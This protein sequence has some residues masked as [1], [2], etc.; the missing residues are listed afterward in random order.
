[1]STNQQ[2]LCLVVKGNEGYSKNYMKVNKINL[3]W[4]ASIVWLLAGFNVLKIGVETYREY[5]T[6]LNVF[7]SLIIFIIF[8]V[9]VFKKLVIKHTKR[10]LAFTE[11]QYFWNFFDFRSFMIMAFMIGFGIIIRG[12]NLAPDIFIAVF[13]TGLGAALFLAGVLFG[14]AYFKNRKGK[15]IMK[16]LLDLAFGY[17]IAAM[18]GGVF[19]REFT[20]FNAFESTT[21][22]AFVHLHL[23]VLGTFLFL[24]LFLFVKQIPLAEERNFKRFMILYNISLPFMVGMFIVRGV[25]QVLETPLSKGMNGM[26]SGFAGISHI[27]MLISFVLLFTSLKK[28]VK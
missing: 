20:K 7:I 21:S 26:I 27:M 18:A 17:F 8:W 25:L 23:M 19:Y 10:I 1:M 14:V 3:L 9:M 12:F 28:A 15:T 6:L 5:L 16:K 2:Y 24:L 11:K 22:L 13:Y 4:I